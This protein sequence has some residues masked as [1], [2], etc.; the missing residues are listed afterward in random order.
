MRAAEGRVI[1]AGA[2]VSEL[3]ERAGTGVAEWV[4]RL[5]AG[6]P[7]LIL[8]GPGN[9]GGDGYVAARVLAGRGMNVRVA[10]LGD[11]RTEAAAEARKAWAGP[12]EP[13]PEPLSNID[14]YAGVY[15]DAA[16]G[17]GLNRP[18]PE[19]MSAVIEQLVPH[20]LCVDT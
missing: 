12:V 18:L 3:M 14:A 11:P 20:V 15:V 5:A 8:C 13:V 10:A 19:S 4:H 17:T 6:A 16:F 7:V 2:S 9:N 1:A